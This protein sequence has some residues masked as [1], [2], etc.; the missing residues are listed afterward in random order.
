M[1]KR[2]KQELSDLTFKKPVAIR[3][4]DIDRYQRIV[5]R[6]YID[7]LGTSAPIWSGWALPGFT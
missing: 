5:G 4:V 6:I 2:A 7:D 3:V 1:R